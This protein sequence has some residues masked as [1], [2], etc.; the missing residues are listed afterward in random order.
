MPNYAPTAT[1]RVL[2]D[3]VSAGVQHRMQA[4]RPRDEGVS[5]SLVAARG[6]FLGLIS[7]LNALLPTDFAFVDEFYIAQDTDVTTTTGYT[8]PGSIVG[9]VSPAL[10]TPAMKVTDTTFSGKGTVSKTRMGIF[11]VFWDPSDVAGPAANGRA[12]T[13]ESTEITNCLIV[14]NSTQRTYA[15]DG[16]IATFGSYA[17]I[18]VNDDLLGKV[19]R[20]LIS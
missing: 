11:G 8:G 3:Y 20:G 1:P 2:W 5:A 10:Y 9:L 13:S 4:R 19:R 6:T 12:S 17:N 14:L 18:K 15:I 7:A 16:T